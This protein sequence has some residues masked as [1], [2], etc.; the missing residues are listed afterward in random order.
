MRMAPRLRRARSNAAAYQPMRKNM[1]HGVSKRNSIAAS[2]FDE[3]IEQ[4]RTTT[5]PTQLQLQQYFQRR[6]NECTNADIRSHVLAPPL[7]Q[8]TLLNMTEAEIITY[9]YHYVLDEK[10]MQKNGYPVLYGKKPAF[11]RRRFL[12]CVEYRPS[13]KTRPFDVNATE[14]V[15]SHRRRS[16]IRKSSWESLRKTSGSS[17]SNTD[18]DSDDM[19]EINYIESTE[20]RCVR[21]SRAFHVNEHGEYRES[22]SCSFHWGKVTKRDAGRR[23]QTYTCCNQPKF[24]DG[25]TTFKAHVWNGYGPGFNGPFDDYVNTGDRPAFEKGN[26][27][28]ALD[29]EM[30]FTAFGLEIIKISVIAIDGRV[31]YERLVQPSTEIIDYN[32]RFSGI[33]PEHFTNG[34]SI[35]ATLPE[36][37]QELLQFINSKTILI[38][39]ALEN[40]L[41]AL[42]MIHFTCVDTSLTFPHPDGGGMKFGLRFLTEKYLNRT[43]QDSE[44]GHDSAEDSRAC[45][46]LMLYKI[47][48]DFQ[49]PI[50]E[51]RRTRDAFGFY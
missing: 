44:N 32:T 48:E 22:E 3:Y 40:D 43:I 28:Y 26:G 38:G 20:K 11:Y 21:C 10:S 14:F 6:F 41:R 37:Q 47:Y 50:E 13:F 30:G 35:V 16:S 4:H 34:E 5:T 25:C 42:K 46:E 7:H 19:S 27:A 18:S 49:A 24:S 36:V 12:G 39:H 15:P 31:V 1:A 8:F 23:F 2:S 9:L 29:C 45:L 17:A 51:N 33:E